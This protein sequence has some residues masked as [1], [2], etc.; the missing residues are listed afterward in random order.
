MKKLLWKQFLFCTIIPIIIPFILIIPE[1]WVSLPMQLI[2]IGVFLT[3]D[4]LYASRFYKQI[5]TE[6]QKSLLNKTT[7]TAY[8]NAYELSERKRDCIIAK[9]YGE[10]YS[11]PSEK[12]PYDTHNY[13]SEICKNFRDTISQITSISQEHMSVTFIYH[14]IYPTAKDDD[15]SWRWVVGKESTTRTPLDVFVDRDNSLYHYL[16]HGEGKENIN[17]I[18]YNDKKEL[19]Q[20]SHYYMSPR[21][22]DHNQIGSVFAVKV[23]FGNNAHSFV[24]GILLISTYGKRFVEKGNEEYTDIE[25]KNLLLEELFPYYQRLL[26]TE[27]GVLYLKHIDKKH[28]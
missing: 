23:I 22:K 8:S 5:I 24:E 4:L 17:S 11:I 3:L 25:L 20:L 28:T 12:I 18:F 2:S 1:D 6:K 10:D 19:A 14:Y 9:S 15:K 7:R 21:D 13:I 27:L 26:E 16:I